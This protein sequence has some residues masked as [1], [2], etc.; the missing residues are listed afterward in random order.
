MG[1]GKG[2]YYFQGNNNLGVL[3]CHGLTGAPDEMRELGKYLNN[4]GYTVACPQ[5]RGHGMDSDNFSFTS[6]DM[7]FEDIEKA[8][9]DLSSKVNGIYVIGLSMGGAFTVRIAENHNILGLVTMNAPLIG[10][11]IKERF[12]KME[13]EITNVNNLE[14]A[15]KALS[16]YNKF[17]IETGQVNN[18]SK[19]IAPLLIIQSELDIDRYK[20]SSSMLTEY[21]SSKYISRLDFKKSGHVLVLGDERYEVYESIGNFLSKKEKVSF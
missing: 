13:K 15:K 9:L 1:K 14:K 5:Y 2:S 12:D 4:L 3:V 21:T 7:W 6:I 17:V 16:K 19:I 8:F 10:L 11:P 20:I 18:L